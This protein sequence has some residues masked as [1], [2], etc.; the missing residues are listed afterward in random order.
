MGIS[1]F[2]KRATLFGHMG[3]EKLFTEES[4]LSNELICP[5]RLADYIQ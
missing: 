2:E 3:L 1:A 4:L 5:A